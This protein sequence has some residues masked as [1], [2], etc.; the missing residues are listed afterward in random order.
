[1][2]VDYV[3]GRLEALGV[4]TLQAM[5]LSHAHSD[6]F[7]GMGDILTGLH[8]RH[9][10]YNG[11][12]R[13]FFRYQQVIGLAGS[14]AESRNTV[15]EQ[16][17]LFLGASGSTNLRIIPAL[18]TYLGKTNAT[19]SELNDGSLGTVL[20]RGSFSMFLAGDGEVEANLR[21]RETFGAL[22]S[23]MDILKVGHH[24]ANDAVFDNGSF[25]RSRWLEHTDPEV[26]I[27]SG[28][29][30]SHPRIRALQYL[31]NRAGT[32]TYCTNVHGDIELRVDEDG[33]YTISVQ[34]NAGQVCEPGDDATS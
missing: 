18:G 8:V 9:F 24:G 5:I 16:V 21:W 30:T 34:R 28:N 3:V 7:D 10:Y 20:T 2:D 32:S 1:L 14:R 29:G 6:H 31:Q 11:Q 13:D 4:D 15:T 27:I 22:T 17:D 12:V 25:G 33:D 23:D 26:H 19:S